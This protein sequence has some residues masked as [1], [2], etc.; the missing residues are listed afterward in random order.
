MATTKKPARRRDP[1]QHSL[2]VRGD[3]IQARIVTGYNDAGNPLR[4]S[5]TFSNNREG[6]RAAEDWL[7]EQRLALKSGIIVPETMTVSQVAEQWMQSLVTQKR[8]IKTIA[9]YNYTLEHHIVPHIGTMV[10]SKIKVIDVQNVV[11]TWAAINLTPATIDRALRYLRMLFNYAIRMEITE[12][13]I[14]KGV[15]GPNVEKRT[16]GRWTAAEVSIILSYCQTN[17]HFLVNYIQ[18]GIATGLRREELLG[19]RWQD[20]N[21]KQ[22]ELKVEQTVTYHHGKF[23]FGPPKTAASRRTIAL[24][25]ET[26]RALEAQRN[27]V[28]EL[29]LHVGEAWREHGL[30]FPSNVGT[31]MAESR[32]SK[33]F[34]QL[35]TDAGVTRIR[36]CDLR[37]TWASLADEAGLSIK[38]IQDKLGHTTSQ[39][40]LGTYIRLSPE[41]RRAAALPL[42]ALLAAATAATKPA[43][44]TEG[45]Y[46]N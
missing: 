45:D 40:A 8:S 46:A 22:M 7:A 34:R 42:S 35:C 33:R 43:E 4:Q 23:N 41:G 19:L 21:P 24:D 17:K 20:I 15:H 27:E 14:V 13:N 36:L 38:Q 39:M 2:T 1:G 32:I 10:I 25:Q 37:S 31:P 30:I 9:D 28:Q 18:I 5:K 6:K 26:L 3:K 44:P 29:R 12:R 11:N 16:L